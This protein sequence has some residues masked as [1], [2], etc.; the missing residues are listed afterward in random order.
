MGLKPSNE[1]VE[2]PK[3]PSIRASGPKYN[4]D[5]GSCGFTAS[6]V[7]VVPHGKRLTMPPAL[8][9]CVFVVPP[10]HEAQA[11]NSKNKS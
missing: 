8:T 7:G 1:S 6:Y 3:S 11:P 9:S 4:T 5:S 2:F 10:A